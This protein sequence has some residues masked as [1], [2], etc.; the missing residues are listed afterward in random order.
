[1][2]TNIKTRQSGFTLIELLVVISI[3]GIL[4]AIVL[5]SLQKARE[6]AQNAYNQEESHQVQNQLVMYFI[7][8]GYYPNPA[9]ASNVWYCLGTLCETTI[10]DPLGA[11]QGVSGI[12]VVAPKTI[13]TNSLW[14]YLGTKIA[15]AA[16]L[17][18]NFT[19]PGFSQ[20]ANMKGAV[21]YYCS[22]QDPTKADACPVGNA[23]VYTMSV[24]NN[25]ITWTA[26]GAGETGA[27]PTGGGG[28]GNNYTTYN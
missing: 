15:E 1:M 9:Y 21:Y 7:D 19:V 24:S 16:T 6:S 26:R 17:Y 22:T 3:I 14:A 18:P 25:T 12:S 5:V 13:K 10:I 20:F 8:H 27:A 2:K 11:T 28:N 4:S 23:W